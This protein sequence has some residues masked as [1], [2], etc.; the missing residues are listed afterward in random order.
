MARLY[1]IAERYR[2]LEALLEDEFV[3]SS[4]LMDALSQVDDE[5]NEKVKNI[6]CLLKDAEY[7]CNYMKL[8]ED[9]I[10]KKRK[11]LENKIQNLKLYIDANMKLKGTR[12]VEAGTFTI[13]VRKNPP[14]VEVVEFTDIPD[15]FI[16]SKT[17]YSVD[18]KGILEAIKSGE[19]VSGVQLIQTES[20]SIR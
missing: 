3:D 1:D 12:R 5:F 19:E 4:M 8:E 9:R 16:K 14:K 6:C 11:I 2:A 10:N 20:L 15:R 17:E 13:T 7:R 18:R